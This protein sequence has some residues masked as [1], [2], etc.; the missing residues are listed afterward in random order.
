MVGQ[1]RRRSAAPVHENASARSPFV[2]FRCHLIEYNHR[3]SC[4]RR[5]SPST[6]RSFPDH[7]ES[8]SD[9]LEVRSLCSEYRAVSRS[10]AIY[11]LNSSSSSAAR[12]PDKPHNDFRIAFPFLHG[13]SPGFR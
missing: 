8:T 7:V 1:R 6:S 11:R 10:F 13:R 2:Y 5:N 3:N 4:S 12:N 9:H